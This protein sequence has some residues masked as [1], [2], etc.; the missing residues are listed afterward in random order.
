[1]RYTKN[2]NEYVE[3]L[4]ESAPRIPNSEH[5]WK[6]KGKS[7]KDVCLIFHDDMDGI[8]SAIL[9]KKYLLNH[10]FKIKQYGVINYQEGWQA[11][12]IDSRL[13]T[14]ALDFA[15]DIPGVSV[16][17]DH[18]GSFLEEERLT[19]KRYSIKTETGS[20]A[21]GIARQLGVPFS[22]DIKKWIDMIDSAK[23]SGYNVDIAGI[24]DFNLKTIIKHP[25]AKLKFAAA[26]NQLL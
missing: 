13:I 4:L 15:E 7:G 16:Y 8:V 22:D 12:R 18:H 20:A 19:Q 26:F 3:F 23:Y 5:Y 25:E 9:V 11:F 21:E 1:M 24:L 10:G 2:F 6:K 17:M 14:I